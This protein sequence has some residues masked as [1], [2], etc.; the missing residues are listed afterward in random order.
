M[1]R[2]DVAWH[3]TAWHGMAWHGMVRHGMAWHG[4]AWHAMAQ[5]RSAPNRRATAQFQS[6]LHLTRQVKDDDDEWTR[7]EVPFIPLKRNFGGR[8]GL[9]GAV[10]NGTRLVHCGG[11]DMLNVLRYSSTCHAIDIVAGDLEFE[12][13][14]ELPTELLNMCYASD[15]NV[16]V[17]AGGLD[18]V[19][20]T[21]DDD[22]LILEG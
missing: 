7:Y 22:F 17:A 13:L 11:Q 12:L 16:M 3:C 5:H 21:F 1:A 2:H 8:G 15:G 4:R 9:T 6:S 18:R 19:S 10:N 14:A 20:L